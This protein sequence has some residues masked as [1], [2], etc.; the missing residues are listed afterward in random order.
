MK[1]LLKRTLF[2]KL[3][4]ILGSERSI[5]TLESQ[6]A[7]FFGALGLGHLNDSNTFQIVKLESLEPVS[8][9]AGWGHSVV[10]TKCGKLV[11]FGRPYDFQTIMR[12]NQ[13]SVVSTAFARFVSGWTNNFGDIKESGQYILPQIVLGVED[14][15]EC[16]ASA[17]LS[18][19]RTV[20]GS[21]FSMGLNKWGQCGLGTPNIHVYEP[22]FVSR[23]PKI[24]SLDLGLQHCIC[25]GDDERIVSI[26]LSS[27]CKIKET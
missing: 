22:T 4:P 21:V 7:G 8:V 5:A 13:I 25:L 11:T 16:R 19:G 6:G 18:V 9:S 10:V 2:R 12:I 14:V 24:V 27:L 15:V 26:L 23:I 20:N 3:N 17:G 1:S